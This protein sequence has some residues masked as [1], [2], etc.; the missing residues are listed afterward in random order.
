MSQENITAPPPLSLHNWEELAP[1]VAPPL[2][3]GK[4][5]S[6]GYRHSSQIERSYTQDIYEHHKAAAI[7]IAEKCGITVDEAMEKLNP[8]WNDDKWKVIDLEKD[9]LTVGQII[10]TS[11]FPGI[12]TNSKLKNGEY[13]DTIVMMVPDHGSLNTMADFCSN[14][15]EHLHAYTQESLRSFLSMFPT[16]KIEKIEQVIPG[17]SIGCVL[18]KL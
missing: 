5:T 17:W 13:N 14:G 9:D 16:L 6:L 1:I 12:V 4:A 2:T 7:S 15:G 18:I 11:E 10:T 3:L 8:N